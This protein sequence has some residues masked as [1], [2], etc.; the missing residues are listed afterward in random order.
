MAV[1]E[2]NITDNFN[3]MLISVLLHDLRQP[4]ATFITVADMIKH[5]KHIFSEDELFTI[6]ED[7][8]CTASQSIDLMDGLLYWMKSKNSEFA[9]KGQS[10]PLYDMINEANSLQLYEQQHKSIKL[11]NNVPE[12]Q[13]IYA[14][15]EMLQFINRNI[16]NNATKHSPL[17][18]TINVTSSVEKD[19]ITIAFTDQGKGITVDE[20]VN[21]FN[22]HEASNV[23]D[24]QPKGTGIALS[25]C[26]DMIKKMNGKIWAESVPGEGSTF[27]YSLPIVTS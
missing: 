8:R 6:I 27:Y 2:L 9:F 7:M 25:I 16:L 21:L 19:W 22:M 14:C 10:L 1:K 3:D 13:V 5:T 12:L 20:L 4:F 17:G 23:Y 24:S 15:K 26:K 18:A 11:C